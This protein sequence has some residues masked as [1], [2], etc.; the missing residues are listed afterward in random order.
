MILRKKVNN[1]Y[2]IASR[3]ILKNKSVSLKAKG[4]LMQMLS[5]PDNWSFSLNGIV[6][7]SSDGVDSTRTAINELKQLGYLEIKKIDIHGKIDYEWIVSEMSIPY[8]GKPHTEKPYTE[9]PTLL[10]NNNKLITNKE[11]IKEKFSQIEINDIIN[12]LNDK[13]GFN[14]NS[15]TNNTIMLL[16]A[17]KKEGATIEDCKKVIDN[18]CNDWLNDSNFCKYLRP[19]TL[20]SGKFDTYLQQKPKASN[21]PEWYDNYKKNRFNQAEENTQELSQEEQEN[22]KEFFKQK[23]TDLTD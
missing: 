18:K 1:D 8:M 12:Y 5:L 22:F 4:L 7:L 14:Y 2:F 15:K 6:A 20:F 10:I 3:E 13:T 11:T 17:R 16:N 9:N 21:Q 23:N 19:Q